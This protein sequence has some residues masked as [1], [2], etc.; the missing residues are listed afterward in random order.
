MDIKKIDRN[1]VIKSASDEE[2]NF[3]SVKDAPFVVDGLYWF[4]EDK[5]FVRI[6]TDDRHNLSEGVSALADHTSGGCVRFKTNSNVVAIKATVLDNGTMNH[7]TRV[8]SA[9]FD[10][11]VNNEFKYMAVSA[12]QS[13]KIDC[14][15]TIRLGN[16]EKEI[17]INFP[18]YNGVKELYIGLEK[19]AIVSAPSA[20]KI[21]KPV[22][23]YGS[24]I[25]QGGC[26]SRPGNSYTTMI[27]RWLDVPVINFG[28][29]GNAKGEIEMAELIASIDMSCFVMD[30]DHNA[31]TPEHLE[32][33]HEPFFKIIR[34]KHPD[35][36]V[37]FISRANECDL[38]A[39][40]KRCEAIYATYQNALSNG[41]KNVYFL[42]GK[43]IY[44]DE[45][46]DACT[47]DGCHPN[48]LGFYRMGKAICPIVEK[49][50][51]NSNIL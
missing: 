35:M 4:N 5:E 37:I 12:D 24:S 33:T 31:P 27:S 13:D 43:D 51:K 36:P 11:Y 44:T 34:E 45:D 10:I 47:V 32:K 3:Y 22:L 40:V 50:L 7:M 1:F 16:E 26:A 21:D 30:Y 15:P 41:D 14:M 29:S 17:T 46:R 28:F 18:L 25:T 9:G 42:N 20:Y 38:P 2:L 23:F 6:K 39:T 48:D 49:A 19:G 8:G